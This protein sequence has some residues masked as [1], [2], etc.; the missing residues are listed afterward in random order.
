MLILT[1]HDAGHADVNVR[2]L[3]VEPLRKSNNYIPDP[4]PSPAPSAAAGAP[5]DSPQPGTSA[6]GS[7]GLSPSDKQ[8]IQ[9]WDDIVRKGMKLA[10][11]ANPEY[12]VEKGETKCMV[13]KREFDNTKQ[14]KSHVKKVHQGKGKYLCQIGDCEKRFQTRA[15]LNDHEKSKHDNKG[16]T[17]TTCKKVFGTKRALKLHAK[18]HGPVEIFTCRFCDKDFKAKRYWQE[19]EESCWKNP[20]RLTVHCPHC[21]REFHQRKAL[22][23]HVKK[24]H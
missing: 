7:S 9:M 8:K 3:K 17:C 2:L 16:E 12:Q 11:I 21:Q 10:G 23:D 24:Q 22:N 20:N 14:L 6:A 13:C 19:H 4:A 15:A 1:F 18:L 5:P